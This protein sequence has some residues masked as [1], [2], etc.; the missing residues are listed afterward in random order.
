MQRQ[1]QPN[2][3]I[4]LVGNKLDLVPDNG[5]SNV[6][7]SSS[8]TVA[9]KQRQVDIADAQAYADEQNLI[10][11]EASAKAGVNVRQVFERVASRLPKTEAQLA[12]SR[13]NIGLGGSRLNLGVAAGGS[14]ESTTGVFS[15]SCC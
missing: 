5:E 9:R 3:I 12:L 7:D 1:A 4:A 6:K 10:F 11:L 2:I 13:S 15:R 14:Q 8:A